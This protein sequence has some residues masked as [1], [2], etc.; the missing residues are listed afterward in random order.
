[1]P[2]GGPG[3]TPPTGA[4]GRGGTVGKVTALSGDTITLSTFN[5]KTVTVTVTAATV[6][7]E[8]T[9]TSSLSALKKGDVAQVAGSTS[10]D[11]T[12]TASTITFG[13]APSGAP[14]LSGRPTGS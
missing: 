2:T 6:Y 12:V 14:G 1:M 3:G 13:T 4:S 5:N 8:G 9:K 10:S 7:K 11:G